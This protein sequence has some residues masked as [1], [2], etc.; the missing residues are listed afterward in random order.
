MLLRTASSVA[1]TTAS[2]SRSTFSPL[3]KSICRVV[4]FSLAWRATR[5]A[6]LKAKTISPLVV[7]A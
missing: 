3:T 6:V 1:S 4:C 2:Y 5:L 7:A